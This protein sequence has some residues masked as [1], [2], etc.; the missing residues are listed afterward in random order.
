M[1]PGIIT[2]NGPIDRGIHPPQQSRHFPPPMVDRDN[3]PCQLKK[4]ARV[5]CK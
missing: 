5:L 1:A 2:V 3:C 4:T